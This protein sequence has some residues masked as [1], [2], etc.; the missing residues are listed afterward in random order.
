[1]LFSGDSPYEENNPAHIERCHTSSFGYPTEI[2]DISMEEMIDI[3]IAA[4]MRPA[5]AVR[6]GDSFAA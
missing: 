4:L 6:T 3:C 2:E 1:M 5:S